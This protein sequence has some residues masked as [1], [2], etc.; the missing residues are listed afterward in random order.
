[1]VRHTQLLSLIALAW[2]PFRDE[3]GLHIHQ[4]L[5]GAQADREA[6]LQIGQHRRH[7]HSLQV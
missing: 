2:A 4:G 6:A 7:A 1:M 3:R 5:Q